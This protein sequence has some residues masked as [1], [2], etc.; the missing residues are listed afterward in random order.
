MR[1]R[2]IFASVEI[3]PHVFHR[4]I[5]ALYLAHELVVVFFTHRTT[6]D[7]TDLREEHIRTLNG[8]AVLIDLHV[9]S[10]DV[11]RIVGHDDRLPEVVFHQI[12]FMLAGQVDTPRHGILK[13]LS[14]FDCFLKYANALGVGETHEIL[15]EH[16]FETGDETLV[17]HLVEELEIVLAVVEGPFHTILDEVFLQ[18][19]QSLL[20]EESHFGLYHPKLGQMAGRVGVLGTECG[21]ESIDGTKCRGTKFAFELSAHCE[22]SGLAK[23]VVI[24]LDVP[25]L[26]FLKVVEILCGHL[27]HLAGSLTVAG[28]DDGCVEIEE[29]MLVEIAVDGHS[30]VM[31]NAEYGSKGVGAETQVGI[32]AHIFEALPFLL[33]RIVTRAKTVDLYLFALDFGSLSSTLTLH[34]RAHNAQAGTGGDALEQVGIHQGGI[35]NYLYILDC[36]TVVESDEINGFTTAMGTHP[37]FHIDIFSKIGADKSINNFCS[38]HLQT[39]YFLRS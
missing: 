36:R 22:R 26:V 37:S 35:D 7:F 9:E 30:H 18:I 31:A 1:A 15:L 24:I 28:C 13:L 17:Y 33:H 8:A 34:Q 23:E 2:T 3:P 12:T 14:G 5:A 25:F 38:F 21:A 10:L 11:F 19:H 16:S 20:L 29:P 27:K 39:V 32:L 6:D 4:N